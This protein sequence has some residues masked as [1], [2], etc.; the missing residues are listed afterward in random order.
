V[1]R[2]VT[3]GLVTLNAGADAALL[4]DAAAQLPSEKNFSLEKTG[5][6]KPIFLVQTYQNGKNIPNGRKHS[7]W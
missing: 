2:S 5:A 1:E 4:A 6:M 3:V 7:K